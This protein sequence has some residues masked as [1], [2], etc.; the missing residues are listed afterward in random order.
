[1][2][3]IVYFIT[4]IIPALIFA[5]E[6]GEMTI[7]WMAKSAVNMGDEKVTLPQFNPLNFQFDNY[8]KQLFFNF[9]IPITQ[10]IN[11]NSIQITNIVYESIAAA[12]L[13]DLSV[14]AIPNS[15]NATAKNLKSRAELFAMISLSPIIKEGDGY[16]K[17]KSFSYVLTARANRLSSSNSEFTT[18][19]NSVLNTGDWF[20]FY[21]TK[22]GIYKLSKSFLS[23][24][25][26]DVNG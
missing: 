13:G 23:G 6:K 16:K 21:V 24:L 15:T 7:N 20:R 26:V 22:S 11:E 25:G 4:L 17:I 10:E 12:D 9:R 14:L 3:K 5:Q 2:K 8:T 18:L 1:M 19:S